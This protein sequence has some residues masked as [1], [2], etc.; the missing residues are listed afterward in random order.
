VL[1]PVDDG[2]FEHIGS[3]GNSA[4]RQHQ[5]EVHRLPVGSYLVIPTSTGC[6]I[7]QIKEDAAAN[8]KSLVDVT[9]TFLFHFIYF[10]L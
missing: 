4:E 7:E 2:S 9:E 3:S 10:V 1:K 5:F 8:G 6:K